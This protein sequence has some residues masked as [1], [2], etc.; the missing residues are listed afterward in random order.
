MAWAAGRGASNGGGGRTC[1]DPLSLGRLKRVEQLGTGGFGEVWRA[2]WERK[3]GDAGPDVALK[4]TRLGKGRKL[5]V[6]EMNAAVQELMAMTELGRHP[7]IVSASDFFVH[8]DGETEQAYACIVMELCAGGNLRSLVQSHPGGLAPDVAL[9]YLTQLVQALDF[10][11]SQ[12]PDPIVH[13]DIK[14]ENVLM[15]GGGDGGGP[16]DCRLSDFGLSYTCRSVARQGDDDEAWIVGT[17]MFM[18][19]E[20]FGSAEEQLAARG[21]PASDIWSLGCVLYE[22]VTGCDVPT[23]APQPG[24]PPG[25]AAAQRSVLCLGRLCRAEATA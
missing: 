2:R 4:M 17:R 20:W 10:A 3:A 6:D 12:T 5:D 15:S 14:P 9:R 23:L 19:P 7:Y 25:G 18:A 8:R 11:H 16:G 1:I 13:R 22:L 24:S 21:N